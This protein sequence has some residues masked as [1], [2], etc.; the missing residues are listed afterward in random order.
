LQFSSP[1]TRLRVLSFE[2]LAGYGRLAGLDLV[3]AN[4]VV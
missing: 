1:G 4:V 2:I 3:L